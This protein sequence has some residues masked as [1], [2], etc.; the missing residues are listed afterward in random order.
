MRRYRPGRVLVDES[1]VVLQEAKD[2]QTGQK[3]TLLTF[4]A[5]EAGELRKAMM[6]VDIQRRLAGHP[7]CQIYVVD[8]SLQ[9]NNIWHV[10]VAKEHGIRNLG[11]EIRLRQENGN[12][13]S[14]SELFQIGT[15]L[16]DT[17]TAA[18]SFG[19]SGIRLHP[20]NILVRSHGEVIL[21]SCEGAVPMSNESMLWSKAKL[22]A[23]LTQMAVLESR[24][25]SL[26][27]GEALMRTKLP[28]YPQTSQLIS[29]LASNPVPFI[30]ASLPL[31][32]N[33][34]RLCQAC[35]QPFTTPN[36]QANQLRDDY[37]RYPQYLD[38]VCSITCL[39]NYIRYCNTM[40]MELRS[41]QA[42][43]QSFNAQP[44]DQVCSIRCR[45][46]LQNSLS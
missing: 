40:P 1:R 16:N 32:V 34:T 9:P 3:V 41:C 29:S 39:D 35:N 25:L 20:R 13:W 36:F 6:E 27:E 23:I 46:W 42:C 8:L 38:K 30:S 2:T 31:P 7:V 15:S 10:S 26:R 11:L 24:E 18:E 22:A 33:P 14:D 17:L 12:P 45:Q 19:V 28:Q 37:R 44:G 21:G 5:R 4:I 43:G